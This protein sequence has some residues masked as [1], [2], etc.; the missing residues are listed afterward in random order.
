MPSWLVGFGRNYADLRQMALPKVLH[1]YEVGDEDAL[2][3]L[4]PGPARQQ[5]RADFDDD[6]QS[7]RWCCAPEEI[8]KV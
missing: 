1:S 5:P 8:T 4:R 2:A 3:L 7:G 6:H